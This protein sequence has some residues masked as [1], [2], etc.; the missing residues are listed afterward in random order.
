MVEISEGHPDRTK[1]C[2]GGLSL[3]LGARRNSLAQVRPAHA[4]WV[5]GADS[6]DLVEHACYWIAAIF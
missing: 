2:L 6:A 3:H 5:E 4:L 1:C